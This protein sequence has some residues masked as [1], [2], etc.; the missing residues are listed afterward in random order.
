MLKSTPDH[1][2]ADLLSAVPY[3][4]GLDSGSRDLLARAAVRRA[5]QAGQVVILEGETD[6]GLF[7]V[8]KGWLKSVKASPAGREQVIREVGPGEVFNDLGVLAGSPMPATVVALEPAV[9]WVIARDA[10]LHLL[11]HQP[12]LA[13]LV[14][15]NLGQRMLHLVALIEDL[16]LRSV[17]ERLARLLLEQRQDARAARRRP[18]TQ[19]EMAARIGSVPDVVNRALRNLVDQGLIAVD[20]RRIHI[21]DPQGLEARLAGSARGETDKSRRQAG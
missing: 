13:R 10:I 1:R 6:C 7:V 5:C 20:R 9:V 4:A 14:I 12:A 18:L 15:R 11:D 17:E 21:L 8:E 19:A 2:A 16:S 3:F